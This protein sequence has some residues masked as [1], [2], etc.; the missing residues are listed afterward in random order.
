MKKLSSLALDFIEKGFYSTFHLLDITFG[1]T[2]YHITTLPYSVTVI[3]DYIKTFVNYNVTF[4]NSGGLMAV[5]QPKTSTSID[6]STFKLKFADNDFIFRQYCDSASS[7]GK[8]RFRAGFLNTMTDSN[9][10]PISVTSS[11]GTTYLPLSPILD[12]A[13]FVLLYQGAI[14]KPTYMLSDESG[15]IFELECS[16]PMAALDATNSFY[17]TTMSLAQ[18]LPPSVVDTCFE[19]ITLGGRTQELRWGRNTPNS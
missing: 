2:E 4:T 9:G 12:P 6:K 17:T 11:N 10:N 1:Q 3:N 16:S 14:D 7:N 19:D 8:V 5:D 18:R 15:I 13:D